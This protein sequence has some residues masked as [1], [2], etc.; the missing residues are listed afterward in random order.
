MID[1]AA[2]NQAEVLAALYNHSKAQ[3][4]GF[5]QYDPTPMTPEEAARLLEHETSFDYVKGRVL[6]IDL[7]TS[8]LDERLYDR[9]NGEAAARRALAPLF[10]A[11]PAETAST[12]PAVPGGEDA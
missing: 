4:L 10:A 9:D 12:E 7:S 1:I 6:K 3:G 5:L 2:L 8:D 11:V